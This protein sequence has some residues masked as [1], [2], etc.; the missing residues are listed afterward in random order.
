[1]VFFFIF[2]SLLIISMT[3]VLSLSDTY[4]AISIIVMWNIY[5]FPFWYVRP[6]VCSVL[7]L[8]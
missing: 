7:V 2:L 3:F 1:M 8:W 5:A 6:Q 4:V